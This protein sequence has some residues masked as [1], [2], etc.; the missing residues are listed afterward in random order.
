MSER[1]GQASGATS[2]ARAGSH[3]QALVLVAD[4]DLVS[5]LIVHRSL[6]RHDVES[7]DDGS[8]A[9]NM[10]R[11][12]RPDVAVLDWMMP[13]LDGIELCRVVRSDPELAGTILVVITASDDES[14]E[15][16]ARLAGADYFLRK[17]VLPGQLAEL[18]NR[19]LLARDGETRAA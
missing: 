3:G 2:A 16:R 13:G 8:E 12:S 5:R 11:A 4:D 18:V 9:L 6:G 7:V 10:L 15:E 14:T 1:M 19:A 17:P